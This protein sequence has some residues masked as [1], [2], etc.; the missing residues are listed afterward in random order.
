MT[1]CNPARD[2]RGLECLMR[3]RNWRAIRQRVGE[4]GDGEE[5]D[6]TPRSVHVARRS[7]LVLNR[8]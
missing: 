2:G 6:G 8:F 7:R 4:E 3:L 5:G 1:N